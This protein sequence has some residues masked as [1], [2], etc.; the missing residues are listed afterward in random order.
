MKTGA[1][2]KNNNGSNSVACESCE[3]DREELIILDVFGRLFQ[4]FEEIERALSGDIPQIER[5]KYLSN[6]II[7]A[8]SISDPVQS[9]QN[10]LNFSHSIEGKAK[11][12]SY[13][14]EGMNIQPHQADILLTRLIKSS[15]YYENYTK[16]S[17]IKEVFK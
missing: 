13:V 1:I 5:T 14:S 9:I 4:P 3:F 2:F 8:L 15:R 11:M 7:G 12:I 6:V 17:K 10:I 16:Y